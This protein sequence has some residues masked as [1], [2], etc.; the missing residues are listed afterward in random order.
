[1]KTV[2][3]TINSETGE[4]LFPEWGSSIPGTHNSSSLSLF[5]TK[6]NH[7]NSIA[8]QYTFSADEETFD[9]RAREAFTEMFL[10]N[11]FDRAVT[12]SGDDDYYD[13]L[14]DYVDMLT[15]ANEALG[16]FDSE[17]FETFL[18]KLNEALHALHKG[19]KTP[20]E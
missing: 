2:N 7:D 3:F 18:N 5:E 16:A 11:L 9:L 20:E 19:W 1:M 13:Y 6:F 15:Q 17:N 8:Y 12:C 4:Y 14:P 10:P